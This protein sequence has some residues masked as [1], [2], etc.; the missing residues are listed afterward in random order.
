M[1]RMYSQS[2]PLPSFPQCLLQVAEDGPIPSGPWVARVQTVIGGQELLEE[3]A[4]SSK[5]S[6]KQV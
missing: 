6:A 2:W 5:A 4:S 3:Y 1:W